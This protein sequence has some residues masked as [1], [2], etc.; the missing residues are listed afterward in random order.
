MS[1]LKDADAGFTH[2]H[3]HYL[4]MQCTFVFLFPFRKTVFGSL[5]SGM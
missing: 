5:L 2:G 4:F 3:H 1:G